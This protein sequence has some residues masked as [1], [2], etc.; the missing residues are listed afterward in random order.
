MKWTPL[1]RQKSMKV[2][3]VYIHILW[4]T[5]NGKTKPCGKPIKTP[6]RK[7]FTPVE[8]LWTEC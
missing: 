3:L 1:S 4:E 2:K 6:V 5:S 7:G 8:N